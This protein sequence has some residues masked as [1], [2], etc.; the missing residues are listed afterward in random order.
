MEFNSEYVRAL[1]QTIIAA[2]REIGGFKFSRN[3][4]GSIECHSSAVGLYCSPFWR[5]FVSGDTDIPNVINIELQ[6]E[7]DL[8]GEYC[9]IPFEPSLNLAKDVEAYFVEMEKFIKS[10]FG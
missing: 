3:C 2:N 1:Y 5:T 8:I 6:S 10:R 4:S 7:T 9:E